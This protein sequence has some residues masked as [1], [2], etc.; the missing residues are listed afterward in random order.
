MKFKIG[1][2]VYFIK[3]NKVKHGIVFAF[4]YSNYSMNYHN[5]MNNVY[6]EES[7]ARSFPKNIEVYAVKFGDRDANFSVEELFSSQEELMAY[8]QTP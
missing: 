3:N 1:D 7:I 5:T 6:L 2:T 4:T 8:L